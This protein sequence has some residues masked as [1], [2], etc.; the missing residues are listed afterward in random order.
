MLVKVT[1]IE[2]RGYREWT[3][4]LG[5]DREWRIQGAQARLYD[6]AMSAAARR[7][8]MIVPLR[9]DYLLAVTSG[10]EEGSV[11][12]LI[13]E[14]AS[15]SPVALR[16]SSACSSSPSEAARKAFRRLRG[17]DGDECLGDAVAIAYV[18]IDDITGLTENTDPLE[19]YSVIQGLLHRVSSIA[20]PAGGVVQ[21]LGGDN[22]MVLLPL[23]KYEA[24][25]ADIASI[26]RVKVGVGV[27]R[28]AREASALATAALDEI[29]A[30][31]SLGPVRVKAALPSTRYP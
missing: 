24:I 16:H 8:A 30:D 18:D 13:D 31:R 15:A 5:S 4:L 1:L 23:D 19:A 6:V 20:V 14:V 27:G 7:G 22:I 3:E 29:R 17:E 21:Y 12:E 10:L 28:T 26:A 25:S 11:K 9:Y 2:L